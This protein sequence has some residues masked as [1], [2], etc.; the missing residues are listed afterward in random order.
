MFHGFLSSKIVSTIVSFNY[1]KITFITYVC[2]LFLHLSVF[3]EELNN[4]YSI[5]VNFEMKNTLFIFVDIAAF[6]LKNNQA[7]SSLYFLTI[8]CRK[9]IRNI[10]SSCIFDCLQPLSYFFQINLL[11]FLKE[12]RWNIPFK[13]I[14]RVMIRSHLIYQ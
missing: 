12:E 1:I 2:I 9:I 14:A 8:S 4:Y 10:C 13:F 5:I 3:H 6:L 11:F 7:K